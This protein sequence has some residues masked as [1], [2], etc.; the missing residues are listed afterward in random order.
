MNNE[1]LS[2]G[3]WIWGQFNENSTRTLENAKKSVDEILNGSTF[4]VHLTLC[5]P[6]RHFDSPELKKLSDISKRFDPFK[7]YL[8]EVQTKEKFYQSLF[9]KIIEKEDLLGLKNHIDSEFM[10]PKKNFFPHISLFYGKETEE[11]KAEAISK[12]INMNNSFVLDKISLVDVD[13][14]INS[15][16]IFKTYSLFNLP[17]PPR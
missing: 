17:R 1:R 13:E 14:E 8:E 9:I 3:F 15:W 7:I 5:G 2:K 10:M 11:K 6:F 4:N 12:T 16:K